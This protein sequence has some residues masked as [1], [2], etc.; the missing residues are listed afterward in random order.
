MGLSGGISKGYSR[1][2]RISHLYIGWL[3]RLKCAIFNKPQ[4]QGRVGLY[5]CVITAFDLHPMV[6]VHLRGVSLTLP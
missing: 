2:P 3:Y 1:C 5:Q 4:I 6:E